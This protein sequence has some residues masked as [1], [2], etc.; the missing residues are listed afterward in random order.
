MTDREPASDGDGVGVAAVLVSATG[1]GTLA[2]LG[3]FAF[4]GG[5]NIP[6]VLALRFGL[7][8]AVLWPLLL[9]TR[10]Q[11]AL[12]LRGRTLCVA[13]VM[14]FVGYT[15]QSALFF[16]G[17][18]Y[19]TAGITTL[20]LYTYPVF[21]LVL[22]W[23]VLGES[24]TFRRALAVPLA[25]GGIAL[26]AGVDP[27]GVDPVGVLVVLGSAT[28]YSGYITVSRIALDETDGL[29]LA[30]YV[31]PAAATSFLLYGTA[32]GSLE[33]PVGLDTWLVVVAIAVLATVVPVATF[34]AGVRR[35][36]A[37]RA[38]L[39]STFEPVVAVALG[40]VLLDEPLTLV[41]LVGGALVL[42]GVVLVHRDRVPSARTPA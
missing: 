25:L 12:R 26:V 4:A 18:T 22:S 40:V 37:S 30:G 42:V 28:V 39:L 33:L 31:T 9:A 3:E 7:A 20:V 11:S 41:T 15:G 27:T 17:L 29:V 13:L 8:A 35:V 14:G 2:V 32:T 36:G 34:F 19:M 5:A 6:T 1:F 38:G 21:V 10:S 23:A 16:W 24:L